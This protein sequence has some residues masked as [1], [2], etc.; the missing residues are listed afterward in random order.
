MSEYFLGVDGGQSSTVAVIADDSGRIVGWATAGPCNHVAASEG[1]EKFLRVMR[2]CVSQAAARAGMVSDRPR[3]RGACLG[4]SG[5]P[6]DKAGLLQEVFESEHLLVT[7]DGQIALAGATGGAPGIIV[8]AGTGSFAFGENARSETA[9]AGGWGYI[10]GDEGGGFDIVRQSL[11]A[12]LAEHEGWGPRT[13]LT[14]ALLEATSTAN[15]NQTLHLFYTPDWPRSRVAALARVVDDIA[16]QGDPA[17]LEILQRAAMQLAML[18]GTV[19]RQLWNTRDNSSEPVE[20]AWI[21]GVFNSSTVLERFR[22]LVELE[23]NLSAAPPAH[24]P[25]FGAVTLACKLVGVTVLPDQ[26]MVIKS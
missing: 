26:G 12:A 18:A 8:I 4:M 21:G 16:N 11:R 17:A 6:E 5:G 22:M 10:Y 15:A 7:H 13:A 20:L 3:F 14:P 25:A 19:R 9:R 24:S 1:R 2:E 23:D